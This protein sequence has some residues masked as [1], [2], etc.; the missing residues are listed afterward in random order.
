MRTTVDVC[1][2]SVVIA[3]VVNTQSGTVAVIANVLRVSVACSSV[4]VTLGRTSDENHSDNDDSGDDDSSDRHS[5]RGMT[6]SSCASL[7]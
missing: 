4:R 2:R 1:C 5:N 7:I 6:E 3:V